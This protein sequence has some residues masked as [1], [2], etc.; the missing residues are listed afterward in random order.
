MLEISALSCTRVFH[1]AQSAHC[2]CQRCETEPQAWQTYRDFT[3]AMSG[4][5]HEQIS[6]ERV[7]TTVMQTV[8]LSLDMAGK[9]TASC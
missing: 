8:A 6:G 2:P 7:S 1:S 4:T 9:W 5:I 3:F